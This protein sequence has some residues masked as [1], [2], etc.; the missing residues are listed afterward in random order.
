MWK[1]PREPPGRLQHIL[2]P[3]A[4]VAEGLVPWRNNQPGYGKMV[5]K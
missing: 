3:V 1:N 2:V 5:A 4:A